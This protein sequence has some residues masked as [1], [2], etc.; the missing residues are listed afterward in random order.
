MTYP[1]PRGNPSGFNWI[2]AVLTTPASEK[3]AARPS[4]VI[5]RST[6]PTKTARFVDASKDR[7][8]SSRHYTERRWKYLVRLL[9]TF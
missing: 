3:N 7:P 5:D 6:L 1:H 2:L 4:S 9:Q 8:R